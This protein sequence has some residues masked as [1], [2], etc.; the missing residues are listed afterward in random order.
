[1]GRQRGTLVLKT[2]TGQVLVARPGCTAVH[3]VS[4]CSWNTFKQVTFVLD[5]FLSLWHQTV[6]IMLIGA[7]KEESWELLQLTRAGDSQVVLGIEFEET[8]SYSRFRR[9]RCGS[10]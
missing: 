5:F 3:T 2:L 8:T 1:M 4:I 7:K 6:D 9:G 10:C